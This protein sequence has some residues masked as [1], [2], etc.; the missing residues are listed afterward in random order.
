MAV[1][2]SRLHP[3]VFAFLCGLAEPVTR[4]S[5]VFFVLGLADPAMVASGAVKSGRAAS[6]R[7]G[8]RR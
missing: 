6:R 3:S 8:S 1:F 2:D 5:L 7:G 4:I